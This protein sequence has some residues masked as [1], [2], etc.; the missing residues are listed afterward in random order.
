MN[1][2]TYPVTVGRVIALLVLIAC[3]VL[4]LIGRLDIVL[5]L[6]IGGVAFAELVP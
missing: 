4:A 6:L 1:I 5:A 3:F 2:G